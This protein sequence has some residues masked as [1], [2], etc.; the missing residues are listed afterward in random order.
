MLIIYARLASLIDDILPK[1]LTLCT[2]II[3]LMSE[4]AYQAQYLWLYRPIISQ[5]YFLTKLFES[6]LALHSK[7]DFL[8]EVPP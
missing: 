8:L 7:N 2:N 5:F 1:F 6:S 3:D 4:S